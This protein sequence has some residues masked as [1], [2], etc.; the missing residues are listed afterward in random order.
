[1]H[2][3]LVK[4]VDAKAARKLEAL[5]ALHDVKGFDFEDHVMREYKEPDTATHLSGVTDY[6]RSGVSGIEGQLEPYLSG[7]DG[8]ETRYMDVRGYTIPGDQEILPPKHGRD[9]RLTIDMKIQAV[10]E[11][12]LDAGMEEFG[13]KK[14]SIV[15]M[16][17]HT[18]QVLAMASRPHFNLNNREKM[19]ENGFNYAIQAA[20][21]T[22]ST[23]KIIAG[24]AA[25]DQN[26]TTYDTVFD[27]GWGPIK[28][29]GFKVDDD[30]HYGDMPFWKIY[31]KSSNKGTWLLAKLGGIYEGMKRF[32]DYA[33][34]FGYGKKTGIRLIGESKGTLGNTGKPIDFSRGAFG[35]VL[36]ASP[37]QIA[38]AYSVLANGFIKR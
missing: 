4:A 11:E 35:Y 26:L 31:T 2:I 18:G 15:V 7:R 9:V 22:G 14:G 28:E 13:C 24:A 30:Y 20:N 36:T 37:I 34:R 32:Y 12:E 8:V 27:T 3:P 19:N 29:K 10:V 21:E 17:P 5:L 25:L 33:D 6:T 1:M 38:G 23:V 16:D